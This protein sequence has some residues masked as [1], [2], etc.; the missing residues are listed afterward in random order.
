MKLASYEIAHDFNT[1][2]LNF[3][4][5]LP[6]TPSSVGAPNAFYINRPDSTL[7]H[8][9]N[10]LLS[11]F[12]APPKLF[13]AGHGG[14][15]KSTELLHISSNINIQEKF[16]PVLFSIREETDSVDVDVQDLLLAIGS[17]LYRKYKNSGGKLPSKLLEEIDSWRGEVEVEILKKKGKV[18]ESEISAGVAALFA[19]AGLKM[20]IEPDTRK[21]IR[22][23]LK[24]RTQELITIINEIS[25]AIYTRENRMP[26]IIIDDLDKLDLGIAKH[27]FGQCLDTLLSPN[28]AIIYLISQT[29]FYSNEIESIRAI[30]ERSY[31]ISAIRLHKGKKMKKIDERGYQA[32]ES[33]VLM[34]IS[35]KLITDEALNRAIIFSGGIPRELCRLVRTAIGRARYKQRNSISVEDVEWAI[36][37]MINEYRRFLDR[38]DWAELAKIKTGEFYWSEKIAPLLRLLA[39]MEYMDENG[40]V[41]HDVH[42]ILSKLL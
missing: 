17:Q 26:L 39:V 37:L 5:D 9:Y 41:W 3:E 1:A 20:K 16:W 27:I 6:L 22:Q 8:L 29:L 35:R 31:I 28:C 33:M 18:V 38:N 19:N 10:E 12:Y 2:W 14:T 42:P 21:T 23:I 15:G 24:P 25:S 34:R 30:R 7:N 4:L 11:P 36:S 32:L 40:K 13:I